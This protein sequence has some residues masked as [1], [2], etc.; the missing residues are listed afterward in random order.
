M[1]IIKKSD[2]F[3]AGT[4]LLIALVTLGIFRLATALQSTGNVYAKVIYQDELIL[5]IDLSTNDYITYPETAQYVQANRL[6][7]SQ[8]A[9][10]IFYVPGTTTLLMEELYLTDT[11]ARDQ[12]LVA[13]K[14]MVQN[15][16]ISVVY[17][18]SPHD[19]CEYQKP[20]NS[21]LEPLVC[22]PNELVVTVV[23]NLPS[24]SFVPDGVLE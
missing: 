23:T 5:M 12:G 3:F 13:V 1:V 22:L 14:L 2:I 20:T 16:K 11:Y 24:D 10:G 6:D 18:E 15:G 4:I 9:Q 21:S 17:Q 7:L 8:A 19:L